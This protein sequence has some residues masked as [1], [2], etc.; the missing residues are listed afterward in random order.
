MSF[1][2]KEITCEFSIDDEIRRIRMGNVTNDTIIAEL[3]EMRRYFENALDRIST[4]EAF[5]GINQKTDKVKIK[6]ITKPTSGTKEI[7]NIILVEKDDDVPDNYESILLITDENY[8]D[9]V[10]IENDNLQ[11]LCKEIIFNQNGVV[12]NLPDVITTSKYA[13][14]NGT[15]EWEL[16]EKE[17]TSQSVDSQ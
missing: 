1:V 10:F 3:G 9:L 17:V 12:L 4:F 5:L 6:K 14:L 7:L 15:G 11:D 13:I 2:E 8:G 16:R